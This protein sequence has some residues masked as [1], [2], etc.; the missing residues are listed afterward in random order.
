MTSL[1][2]LPGLYPLPQNIAVFRALQ[3]GDMLCSV[4]A[5]RALRQ[6]LPHA[7]I[8]LIGLPNATG[9]V[10][11]FSRYLDHL[12]VFPGMAGMPEQTARP[13]ALP[14]FYAAAR[15]CRFDLA[16]QLHGSGGMTNAIVQQL[17]ARHCAGFVPN[18]DDSVPPAQPGSMQAGGPVQD[19]TTEAHGPPPDRRFFMP[20]PD[21]LPEIL[22]YTALMRHLGIP[23]G[24]T[25]LEFP[26]SAE[27]HAGAI[28]LLR[29]HK[30]DPH[31]TVIVHPGARLPSRRWPVQRF[32]QVANRLAA[33]GWQI[34]ITGS[35]D[36]RLI[37]QSL[38]AAMQDPANQP[39]VDLTGAT[40]LGVLAALVAR[41]RLVVSNDT[42]IS[43]VAAA[44]QTPSVVI[45][46]GSDVHRWAPLDQERHT[47]LWHDLPCRPCAHHECPYPGH[48]CA[49]GIAPDAVTHQAYRKLAQR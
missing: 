10:Q 24:S 46:S 12:M 14:S 22:R 49:N 15:A 36:E 30:L 19:I 13:E 29:A 20:W 2:I 18:E 39:P 26:L 44:V 28:R 48:P 16:I 38:L 7:H 37:T 40:S 21:H 43:H 23:V 42:G 9:F 25:D 32:A 35:Q 31:R 34:A 17:G 8:T 3:L 47:V 27:D 1:S 33:Q 5:L 45:A 4:P 6:A 11:R 41:C